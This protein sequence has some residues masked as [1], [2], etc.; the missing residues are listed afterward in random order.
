MVDDKK[1][2]IFG[3]SAKC[4]CSHIKNLFY[5]FVDDNIDNKIHRNRDVCRLP[6]KLCEYTII[7]FIRNPYKRIVSGFLDKYKKNG[8][9]RNK[10]KKQ[11]PLTF[12]NFVNEL[13]SPNHNF[14]IIDKHH[15]TPQLSEHFNQNIYNNKN[16][17]I[18]DIEKIDYSNLEKLFNKKIPNEVLNFKGT[19]T[20][21]GQ[22]DVNYNVYDLPIDTIIEQNLKP[23]T[24]YFYNDEI[25][26]KIARFYQIDLFF[27]KLYGFNYNFF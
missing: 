12:N 23:K 26:E 24:N 6:N 3:W 13:C 7:L 8:E 18:Y 5:F 27:F 20:F 10:W 21:R 19:H 25:K 22:I 1:K 4:G 2:I 17:I 15:F 9:F 11:V 16:N 14:K